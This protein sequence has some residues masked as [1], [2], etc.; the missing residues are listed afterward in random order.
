VLLYVT[1]TSAQTLSALDLDYISGSGVDYFGI[2]FADG[3]TEVVYYSQ[4]DSRWKY[5]LYGRAGTVGEEGCGPAALAIVISTLMGQT[6][7]PLDVANWA[8]ANGY[9]CVG[10]G[11]Y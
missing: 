2:T 8:T 6:V 7:T 5:A 4:L 3:A 1:A 9:R 10:R 11:S